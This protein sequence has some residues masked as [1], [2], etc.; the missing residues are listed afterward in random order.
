[1]M[2]NCSSKLHN[3]VIYVTVRAVNGLAF[4]HQSAIT[5]M[6]IESII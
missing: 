6:V 3:K 5:F 2:C 1:V 4:R